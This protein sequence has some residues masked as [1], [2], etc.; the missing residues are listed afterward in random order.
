MDPMTEM[1]ERELATFD[2]QLDHELYLDCILE[3]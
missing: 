1:F 2:E 3:Q